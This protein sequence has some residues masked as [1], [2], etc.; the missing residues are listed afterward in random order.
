MAK[1]KTKTKTSRNTKKNTKKIRNLKGGFMGFN[2]TSNDNWLN[3]NNISQNA[4]DMWNNISQS[5]K[6]IWDRTKQSLST[7][8]NNYSYYGN[9]G[10]GTI[11]GKKRKNIRG[12]YDPN[13][14][15]TN[16]ASNAAS[17]SQPTASPQ[18]WLTGGKSR[19]S[20]KSRKSKK[21]RH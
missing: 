19:K 13:I 2:E 11:G 1:L 9:T 5:A 16:I 21:I 7:T 4:S 10:T 18:I 3:I 20:N 8:Q 12:G 6:D 14:S 17:T 15:L